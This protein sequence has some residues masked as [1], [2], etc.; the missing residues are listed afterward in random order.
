VLKLGS[1]T[2][3]ADKA[4]AEFFDKLEMEVDPEIDNAYDLVLSDG[5]SL[6]KCLLEPKL[7]PLV[8]CGVL[9]TLYMV[10]VLS[11]RVVRVQDEPKKQS[12]LPGKVR[13]CLIVD[14]E[15]NQGC[16]QITN[17]LNSNF[18]D[19]A[20]SSTGMMYLNL[21]SGEMFDWDEGDPQTPHS[22]GCNYFKYPLVPST[23]LYLP[24]TSDESLNSSIHITG[25][26]SSF[27]A[28]YGQHCCDA[29]HRGEDGAI[30]SQAEEDYASSL[31]SG[32]CHFVD[33]TWL[34][35][36]ANKMSTGCEPK[37]VAETLKHGAEELTKKNKVDD[38]KRVSLVLHGVEVVG[39]VW[40]I[41]YPR[42]YSPKKR[43]TVPLTMSF[44]L[45]DKWQSATENPESITLTLW[46]APVRKYFNR[47]GL[48]DCV[49]IGAPRFKIYGKNFELVYTRDTTL[50]FGPN[51]SERFAG[52]PVPLLS[53]EALESAAM[54]K[55][56]TVTVVGLLTFVGKR[57]I[58]VRAKGKFEYRWI[59]VMQQPK[60]VELV[61][62]VFS[63]SQF[64]Q[65]IML[66]A[67]QIFAC[68]NV[69]LITGFVSS[70]VPLTI[71]GKTTFSST[72]AQGEAVS[73][74][75]PLN[76]V[77][78]CVQKLAKQ[79]PNINKAEYY[80]HIMYIPSPGT[81][82][83]LDTSPRPR[84]RKGVQA[85]SRAHTHPIDFI[86][87]ANPD[88]ELF[89]AFFETGTH[90]IPR[91]SLMLSNHWATF[92]N[93]FPPFT[94][95]DTPQLESTYNTMH[96]GETRSYLVHGEMED[97]EM[98]I[99]QQGDGTMVY[100]ALISIVDGTEEV[101]ISMERDAIIGPVPSSASM[102]EEK[103]ALGYFQSKIPHYELQLKRGSTH[104]SISK[105]GNDKPVDFWITSHKRAY[106]T[107]ILKLHGTFDSRTS[108]D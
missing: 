13:N 25:P 72:F 51:K 29:D 14:L 22:D 77:N 59:R 6:V 58:M 89:P 9:Q 73:D 107:V 24:L 70:N 39:I 49:K 44:Q 92:R 15:V 74:I 68:T 30:T 84:R 85:T 7:A 42:T 48:G 8:E 101:N 27:P 21:D 98:N 91:V 33:S 99:V 32:L 18:Y 38:T 87:D 3:F 71:C 95:I 90:Y 43:T 26:Y 16:K 105:V 82:F 36:A 50:W 64:S 103:S 52:P 57:E 81:P 1:C 20:R 10:R 80:E 76:T 12:S 11:F 62:Q 2:R 83:Q 53:Q 75:I 69:R 19:E 28:V 67:G 17:N 46:G 93:Q 100:A 31:R 47:V 108:E 4:D 61:M 65:Y 104:V 96:I 40:R 34:S 63:N 106:D 78:K 86:M 79:Y 56:K 37:S 88:Q 60:G 45:I 66:R 94:R 54:R 102:S 23:S 41:E 97:F 35:T 5:G 55:Y